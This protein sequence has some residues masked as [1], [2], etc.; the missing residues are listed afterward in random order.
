M[1]CSIEHAYHRISHDFVVAVPWQN[2]LILE[3][4]TQREELVTVKLADFGA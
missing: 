3:E 2:I 4:T 1:S